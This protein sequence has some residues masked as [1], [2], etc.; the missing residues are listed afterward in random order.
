LF[1]SQFA[2]SFLQTA[3]HTRWLDRLLLV[4]IACS[5]VVVGLSLMTSYAL[6]LRLATTLALVFIVVIFAAGVFA[7]WRGLR[8]ARYFI[9]AWT[10]FLLGGIV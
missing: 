3:S 8:V 10:A 4:L 2:R 6:A 1:G 9:I 5:A 7:W